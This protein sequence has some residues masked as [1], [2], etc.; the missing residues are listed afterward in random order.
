MKRVVDMGR[1]IREQE[2]MAELNQARFNSVIKA[3][4][5]SREENSSQEPNEENKDK[6]E[7][8]DFWI[9]GS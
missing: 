5:E 4:R 2:M 9:G 8:A 6:S 7:S 1:L 3:I